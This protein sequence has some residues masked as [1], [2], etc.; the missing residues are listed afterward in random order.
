MQSLG[1][2]WTTLLKGNCKGKP[3][4]GKDWHSNPL[5][6][7][8]KL[9]GD[10]RQPSIPSKTGVPTLTQSYNP[11]KDGQ[12]FSVPTLK[13]SRPQYWKA[14]KVTFAVQAR[15]LISQ[16]PWTGKHL[17]NGTGSPPDFYLSKILTPAPTPSP[18]QNFLKGNGQDHLEPMKVWGRR[19][20][21]PCLQGQS[22]R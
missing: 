16:A 20:K 14:L 8:N 22:S 5:S 2:N 7:G 3:A 15:R 10:S 19:K 4:M 11:S 18:H 6:A 12:S 21:K 9:R 1:L 17:R 13:G